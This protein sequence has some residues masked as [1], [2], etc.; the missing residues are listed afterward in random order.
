MDSRRG[1]YRR[2]DEMDSQAER[3]GTAGGGGAAAQQ[4][5]QGLPSGEHSD[6]N[7]SGPSG[8]GIVS[9]EIP[10]GAA[11][12]GIEWRSP[13]SGTVAAIGHDAARGELYVRWSRGSRVSIYGPG[14][15]AEE[16]SR[17]MNAT[18]VGSEVY[19][20]RAR[21]QDENDALGHRYADAP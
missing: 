21:V 13:W 1:A 8:A 15:S 4:P 2:S 16:A 9:G 7:A 20:L 17:I 6:A 19:R 18:S 10:S 11:A 14:I 12:P 3:Q 5:A